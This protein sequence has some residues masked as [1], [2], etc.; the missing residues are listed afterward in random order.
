MNL[1]V[2]KASRDSSAKNLAAVQHGLIGYEQRECWIRW[3]VT[4]QV[5]G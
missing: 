1:A 4:C 5:S 2:L 3:T